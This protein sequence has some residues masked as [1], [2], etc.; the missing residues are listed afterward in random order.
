MATCMMGAAGNPMKMAM[1]AFSFINCAKEKCNVVQ[2]MD[3]ELVMLNS[4]VGASN[5]IVDIIKEVRDFR[6]T[7][8]SIKIYTN[9]LVLRA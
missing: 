6:L 9:S 7:Y 1:C 5:G 3:Y 4:H 2:E 8:G